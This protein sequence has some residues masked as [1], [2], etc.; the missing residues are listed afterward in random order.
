MNRMESLLE[1]SKLALGYA[2]GI[3]LQLSA[4]SIK[5]GRGLVVGLVGANGSG[6]ST[7][8]K[9]CLGLVQP[10]RG[11]VRLLGESP[12]TRRFRAMLGRVGYVPQA[13]PAGALRLTVKEV[14]ECG[15]YGRVGFLRPW[16]EEDRRAVSRAMEK[17]GVAALAKKAVQELSGGQYQRVQIARALA[18]EP[19]LLILDEPNSHLD[20][21]GRVGVTDL[22]VGLA[23]E[24]QASMLVVTHDDGLLGIA[25]AWLRF[26]DGGAEYR[27]A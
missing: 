20:S 10:L 16:R 27:H 18:A 13:R 2:S 7:L 21:E 17:A 9:A 15:R 3:V 14:V 11:V 23:R 25:D 1:A 12:G 19:D 22:I 5:G 6:K 4:L 24:R 8:I 26:A